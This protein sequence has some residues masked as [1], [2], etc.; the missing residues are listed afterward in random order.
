MADIIEIDATAE[1]L[2]AAAKSTKWTKQMISDLVYPR[3]SVIFFSMQK[4]SSEINEMLGT[5]FLWEDFGQF[6][7]EDGSNIYCY[8]RS[9]FT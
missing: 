3:G 1:E 2:E 8:H 6:Q 7:S 5:N 9:Y 4:T